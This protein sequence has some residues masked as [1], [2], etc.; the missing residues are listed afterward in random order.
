MEADEVEELIRLASIDVCDTGIHPP[1]PC[2]IREFVAVAIRYAGICADALIVAILHPIAYQGCSS[3]LARSL[4]VAGAHLTR[5]C[6][7][8]YP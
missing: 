6:E 1:Y 2:V 7:P 8:R 4:N 3:Q 5:R